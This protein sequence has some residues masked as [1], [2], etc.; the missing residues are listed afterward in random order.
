MTSPIENTKRVRAL[1]SNLIKR[2]PRSPNNKASLDA[3][4]SEKLTELL[5]IYINWC[6][7]HV[8]CRPRKVTGLS[9]LDGDIRAVRLKPNIEAFV[10]A[11]ETG[12]DLTAYLSLKIHKQGYSPASPEK[13]SSTKAG[14]WRDKDFFLNV[15]GLHH[16]H[17]GLTQEAAGHMARTNQLIFASVTRDT[18]E[19]LGLF[20]HAAFEKEDNDE[21]TSER[22]RLWLTY[23]KRQ[24]A[25]ALPGQLMVGGFGGMGI[26]TAG[27]S[28]A[29]T[30]AAQSHVRIIRE[31]EPKLHDPV[32]LETLYRQSGV[33]KRP[34]VQWHYKHLNFGLLDESAGFFGILMK[35]PN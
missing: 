27:T 7:R 35:G 22:E 5:R 28:A 18:F 32:F 8:A 6:L 25:G 33:P 23:I 3:I 29:G 19:I 34:K 1:R 14:T 10:R 17:L 2:I 11:V 21:M 26:T 30:I 9:K 12:D 31:I 24:E 15:M 16:F 4:K 13:E 20:D